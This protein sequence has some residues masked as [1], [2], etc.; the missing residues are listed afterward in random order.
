MTPKDRDAKEVPP[1]EPKAEEKPTLSPEEEASALRQ[2]AEEAV[3]RAE[4]A[5][6]EAKA[7][8]QAAFKASRERDEAL[9][10]RVTP[11]D[12]EAIRA[13]Q[14]VF[15]AWMA[16]TLNQPDVGEIGPERKQDYM[17]RF[18]EA[19]DREKAKSEAAK[20][21]KEMAKR[22]Q[23]LDSYQTKT[24]EL[25]LKPTDK[26]YRTIRAYALS[27]DFESA[28]EEIEA[29]KAKE[30]PEESKEPKET[31]EELE[32]RLR[33]EIKGEMYKGVLT[34]EGGEPSATTLK[35]KEIIKRFSEGDPSVSRK[36]Y[37]KAVESL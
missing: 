25:G 13:D 28:D 9:S 8:Q 5:E 20:Y 33:E 3:Q 19:S 7:H 17:K 6:V 10:E 26:A 27:G 2:Q 12:L 11:E 21:Q 30:K 36:D 32:A 4:K 29:I 1:M 34:P 18:Q 37:E 31:R 15:A 22:A 23:K 35:N 16:E 14:R 24:E